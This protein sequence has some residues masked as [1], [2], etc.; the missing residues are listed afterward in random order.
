VGRAGTSSPP[1]SEAWACA[2]PVATALRRASGA[3]TGSTIVGSASQPSSASERPAVRTRARFM[4]PPGDGG[5]GRQGCA[6]LHGRACSARS[7]E[8][9]PRAHVPL[10]RVSDSAYIR[11]PNE[12]RNHADLVPPAAS[13]VEL[14]CH[15]GFSFLDGASH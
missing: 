5:M 11:L 6:I 9:A 4:G 12:T 13:Y 1:A 3:W 10:A 7:F 15:S 14:H 8:A 2:P